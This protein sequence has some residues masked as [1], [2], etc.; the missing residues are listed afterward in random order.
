[1]PPRDSSICVCS[2]L[3]ET[4]AKL[5][6]GGVSRRSSLEKYLA[7]N[8]YALL[9]GLNLEAFPAAF[10]IGFFCFSDECLLGS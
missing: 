2:A 8:P 10:P 1:M 4:Q 3:T 6:D 9:T 7:Q 5:L